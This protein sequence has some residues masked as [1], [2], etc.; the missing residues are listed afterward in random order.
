[1][2][3]GRTH[4]RQDL[5]GSGSVETRPG[6]LQLMDEARAAGLKVAVCSAA[7]KASVVHLPSRSLASVTPRFA[8]YLPNLFEPRPQG[9]CGGLP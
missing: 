4:A 7:T 9:G 3:A 6:V 8:S 2:P 1:M 5:I